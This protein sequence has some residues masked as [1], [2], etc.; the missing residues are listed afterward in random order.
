MNQLTMADCCQRRCCCSRKKCKY[1]YE[2]LRK[3]Y[4]YTQFEIDISRHPSFKIYSTDPWYYGVTSIPT[5]SPHKIICL[6]C[7]SCGKSTVFKA[8][9]YLQSGLHYYDL[10]ECNHIIRQSLVFGMLV[11][12]SKSELL[13]EEYK[14]LR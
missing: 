2:S 1:L 14:E 5:K 3:H 12:L 4:K 8:I 9:Q 10:R 13:Y 6:G 11:L 7:G